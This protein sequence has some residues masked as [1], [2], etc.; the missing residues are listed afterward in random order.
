MSGGQA[1]TA[2][3][4]LRVALAVLDDLADLVAEGETVFAASADRRARVRQL[5]IVVGSRL[6]N[7]CEVMDIPRA[8]GPFGLAIG[9]R[10]ILTY[11]RP[12]RVDDTIVWLTSLHDL[13]ALRGAVSETLD[14]VGA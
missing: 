9:F 14:A 3:A 10:H 11:G 8:T 2:A 7:Y 4:E 1:D 13:A 5:W 6:K 12:D